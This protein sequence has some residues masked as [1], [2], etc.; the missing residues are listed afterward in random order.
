MN[1]F[2]KVF[3]ITGLTIVSAILISVTMAP[4]TARA[5]SCD[6]NSGPA[7]QG[8]VVLA[9]DSTV[10]VTVN[11]I[12][13]DLRDTDYFGLSSPTKITFGEAHSSSNGSY[14][15]GN[16]KAGTELIFFLYDATHGNTWY[17]GPASRNSDGQVHADF[18][19]VGTNNWTIGFNDAA[20]PADNNLF[21][22]IVINVTATPS[23]TANSTKQC[24]GNAV[25][26][27]NS[28]GTKGS[29]FQQCTSTQTCTNA[30]CVNNCT[31][32]TAKQCVGNAVYNFNSCGVQGTL[33]QQCTS[34]Q[35]CQNAQCVNIAC[36]S[37]T[38]C[39]ANAYTGSPFCQGNSVYQNYITYTCN[40]PGTASSSCSN[41][42][43]AQKKNDCTANQTCSNGACVNQTI[44]CTSN[45]DCGAN[46]YTGSPF[47]QGNSVYQ[48]YI[49]Y[50]CNN[51]GTSTSYCSNNTA[52][53]KK[54][55]CTAN[56][57]CANGSCTNQNITCTSNTDCGTNSYTGSPF[58]QS[59][60]VYQ[61]YITYTCTNPGTAS[62]YCSNNTASQLK[63]TC[64]SGQTCAN[65]SCSNQTITCTSNTDCGANAYTGSPFCQ[66]NSV[67]QNYITYTCNNA[68]TSTSYCSNN[69]AAQKKN[70]CT[71]N[72]TCANG[73]CTNQ[74]ITCT[75]N[76]D[77]G[78]NSY[79]GSPF[80]QSGN[81]YQ[82]Y[83]TYTCTNPGTASSY[84]SNNTASQLKTTCASGQTCANGSCSNQ[85]I[86]CT[87]N[88]DCGANA[89][90][91]SPFCQGNSVY[92]NYITYTC[93]NAGTSTSYCS[94][95]TAAQLKTTC[96]G[97]QTCSN[98]SCSTTCTQNSYQQCQGNYLY[99]YNSCGVQE[100]QSQ[101]CP[102]GCSGNSCT[103]NNCTYHSYEQCIGNNLY[104][105]NSCGVQQ[106]LVQ[107]CPNGCSGNT[108]TNN[109]IYAT[110]QTNSATNV[111]NNQATLNG[112]LY[113][114]SNNNNNC[115]NYVW[116]QYGPTTSYGTETNHQTQG[117]SGAFSQIVNLYNNY[118]TNSYH[119]RAA[120]QDCSGNTVY[121]QDMTIYSNNIGTGTLTV[122]K[123]VRDLTTGAGF[124]SS[125]SASP[126]DMLMFM[127][128]LQNTGS[129]DVSNVIARDYLPANLIYNDQLTV[130]CTTNNSNYNN[131]N[132]SN[133]NYTGNISSGV[134][135]NTIYAGQTVTITYQV[136]V[137]GAA[138]F[139]YGSTTLNNNVSV[140]STNGSNPTSS[141]SVIVTRT[142]VYGAST[143]STGLTN[144]FWVDSFFLPLLLTLIGLWMWRSG[145]FFGVEKWLDNKKK[146]RR[147]YKAE[148]ELN[149]RITQIQK[150]ERV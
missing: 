64:A 106:D 140:S 90:T 70:D 145:V 130:A 32:N 46:A 108:C 10:T 59:G 138:N 119:F 121:G 18:R 33:Y 105:Y 139:S 41:S 131:C 111:N 51:A 14:N 124:A 2:L 144:N 71:A 34:N 141:A 101:Y 45:T 65:G 95:N 6:G 104:W 52:A 30:Q 76:T 39:G 146:I 19:N 142:A 81:V 56:Q 109:N 137:A 7:N 86:T 129:Q 103:N 120:A 22:D 37:N 78:T 62:S 127:I 20:Y 77:C 133:Y 13:N 92:Q 16:F 48:N 85:T 21:N 11:Y 149:H 116:F 67:Y 40:N 150:T 69:T 28:C 5:L 134:N 79:T 112:Y 68:G 15:A 102:N 113:S 100:G 31:P 50:T 63:T 125:T 36:S 17:T 12:C 122:N 107:Y 115:T 38:D 55:D 42:T 43:A 66:G 126:S 35:I 136:Q 25:Y 3:V 114:G 54:N 49:T 147:G 93:N 8:T 75:S 123:T 132:G 128:T 53:Q 143:V 148:K 117:Y 27:Y 83:I 60:N 97:N 110:V 73:S 26:W 29:L 61:N 72:Q 91:G 58:C 57:T 118:N 4:A 80:C 47:C 96:T 24:S 23:C 74:N 84:C 98:G 87:S 82:N 9:Q 1:T 44:T 94:N 135:L 88:T 89:Y 99:W